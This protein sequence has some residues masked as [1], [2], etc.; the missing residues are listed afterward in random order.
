MLSAQRVDSAGNE[1]S[2]KVWATS[3][4]SGLR[5]RHTFPINLLNELESQLSVLLAYNCP[6]GVP[7]ILSPHP[8][9][10]RIEHTHAC[11]Q[12]HAG[13]H[14][15]IHTYTSEVSTRTTHAYK[16]SKVKVQSDG[17]QVAEDPR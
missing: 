13:S 15:C 12:A 1:K 2:L 11:K 3:E 4:K 7:M 6:K 16:H 17:R 9:K 8:D 14:V 5:S 10:D